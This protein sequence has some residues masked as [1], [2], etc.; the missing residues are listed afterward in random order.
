MIYGSQE[1]PGQMHKQ[2]FDKQRLSDDLLFVG[3]RD[4]RVF[5]TTGPEDWELTCL[6]IK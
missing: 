1:N 4:V 5:N 6:A 2:G 3:F